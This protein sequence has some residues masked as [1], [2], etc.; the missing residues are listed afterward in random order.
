MTPLEDDDTQAV[1]ESCVKTMAVEMPQRYACSGCC[2][3]PREERKAGG[4]GRS[5]LRALSRRCACMC[6]GEHGQGGEGEGEDGEGDG[7]GGTGAARRGQQGQLGAVRSEDDG[8]HGEDGRVDVDAGRRLAIGCDGEHGGW[9][10]SRGW[11]RSCRMAF[12]SWDGRRAARLG[13]HGGN[14]CAQALAYEFGGDGGELGGGGGERVVGRA[15]ADGVQKRMRKKGFP[16]TGT[17]WKKRSRTHVGWWQRPTDR[18]MLAHASKQQRLPEQWGQQDGTE[19]TQEKADEHPETDTKRPD[20]HRNRDLDGLTSHIVEAKTNQQFKHPFRRNHTGN[21]TNRVI[22]NQSRNGDCREAFRARRHG[23]YRLP[24][25][26]HG[27]GTRNTS[28]HQ[29][30]PIIALGII[31]VLFV[32]G[33]DYP[34]HETLETEYG[35][36]WN[37]FILLALL[38]ASVFGLKHYVRTATRVNLISANKEGLASLAGYLSIHLLG[39]SIGTL[40][41]PPSP[42]SSVACERR[43]TLAELGAPRQ[44]DKGAVELASYALVWLTSLTSYGLAFN[45]SFILGYLVLDTMFF[46]APA[47][48]RK[49]KSALSSPTPTHIP[50]SASLARAP[51]LLPEDWTIT[52]VDVYFYFRVHLGWHLPLPTAFPSMMARS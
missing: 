37:F 4:S 17:T 9:G 7:D 28:A 13:L 31:R 1:P 44:N 34:E 5:A 43:S 21:S 19:G 24:F 39:L 36:H 14:L 38:P 48:P 27:N 12:G 3:E 45:T 25:P 11:R 2:T 41:L 15:R 26:H 52:I 33:T 22:R 40:I 10:S 18:V 49:S 35:V 8:V 42:T 16:N 29:R 30:S 47:A 50:A 46:P 23:T 32:K 6:D 20:Q 51:P